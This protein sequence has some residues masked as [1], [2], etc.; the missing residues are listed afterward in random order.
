MP[1]NEN[2]SILDYTDYRDFLSAKFRYLK[3]VKKN[4]SYAIAA[5]KTNVAQS[6]YKNLFRK[7]R[8]VGL[9]NLGRVC[10]TFELTVTE[11]IYLLFNLVSQVAQDPK[12]ADI[13]ESNLGALVAEIR[14]TKKGDLR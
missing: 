6:Y 14:K 13:Y 3:K 8:H 11:E 7:D 1:T 10:R 4:F 5:R 12:I 9:E 2:P